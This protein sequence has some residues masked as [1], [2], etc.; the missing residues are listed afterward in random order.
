M[1]LCKPLL[2]AEA[3]CLRAADSSTVE[4]VSHHRAA[5]RSDRQVD[6]R[7]LGTIGQLDAVGWVVMDLTCNLPGNACGPDGSLNL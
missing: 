3:S 1:R 7:Q 4:T 2:V 5:S 6:Q